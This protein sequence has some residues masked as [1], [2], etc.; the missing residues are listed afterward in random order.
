MNLMTVMS[1][2]KINTAIDFKLIQ[3]YTIIFIHDNIVPLKD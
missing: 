3:F 2:S 1:K